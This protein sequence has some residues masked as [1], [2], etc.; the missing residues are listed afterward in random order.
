M[1]VSRPQK[2]ACMYACERNPFHLQRFSSAR[3]SRNHIFP[4]KP[5]SLILNSI[6]FTHSLSLS[7][8]ICK[9]TQ[10]RF[11]FINVSPVVM[12]SVS[13]AP[14]SLPTDPTR[15]AVNCSVSRKTVERSV[16]RTMDDDHE[17][18]LRRAAQKPSSPLP[19]SP[20]LAQSRRGRSPAHRVRSRSFDHSLTFSRACLRPLQRGDDCSRKEGRLD[21][22]L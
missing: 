17:V 22:H 2:R 4:D 5:P 3:V 14:R 6:S 21:V 16:V 18:K 20:I 12:Q 7:L 13:T 10:F 8:S 15:P 9:M 11:V 19:F 1:N